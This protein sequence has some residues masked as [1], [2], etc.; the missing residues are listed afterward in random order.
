MT[1][2]TAIALTAWFNAFR[3]SEA[4]FATRSVGDVVRELNC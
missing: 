3:I 1:T 2:T 4:P